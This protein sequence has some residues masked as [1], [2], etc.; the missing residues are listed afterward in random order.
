MCGQVVKALVTVRTIQSGD[1]KGELANQIS[2]LA[3]RD[4]AFEAPEATAV[5]RQPDA[6]EIF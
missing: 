6:E 4:P 1:R 3:P 2:K 5:G